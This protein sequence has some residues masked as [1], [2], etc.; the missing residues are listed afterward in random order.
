MSQN[1]LPEPVTYHWMISV[2]TADGR[3]ASNDGRISVTPGVHT[4]ES[5]YAAVRNGVSDWLGTDDFSV[6][7]FS[8]GP[9]QL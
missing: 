9:N 7:S 3:H 8:L 1:S 6:V 4:R 2:Q 5:T